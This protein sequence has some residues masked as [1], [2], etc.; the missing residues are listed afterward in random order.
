MVQGDKSPGEETL[1]KD[2]QES[3]QVGSKKM[4]I[5]RFCQAI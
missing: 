2:A 5:I 4:E 3:P 1:S